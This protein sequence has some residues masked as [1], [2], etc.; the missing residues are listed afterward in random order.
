MKPY[1]LNYS[2]IVEIKPSTY[3]LSGDTTRITETIEQGD[4]SAASVDYTIMTEATETDD[5]D[6]AFNLS[7]STFRTDS[8]ESGDEDEIRDDMQV[9]VSEKNLFLKENIC[10]KE[11]DSTILTFTTEAWDEDE[12]NEFRHCSTVVTRTLEQAD[13]DDISNLSTVVTKTTEAVDEDDI[14]FMSTLLTSSIENS[15]N[16]EIVLV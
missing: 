5:S 7:H 9:K 6:E 11:G 12:I 10:L 13:E 3:F 4:E 14:F 2:E 16:D 1:V 15:D 8:I